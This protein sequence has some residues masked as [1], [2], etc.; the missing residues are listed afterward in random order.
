MRNRLAQCGL[1]VQE[2]TARSVLGARP[3]LSIAQLARRSLVTP[4]SMIEILT[5]LERRELLMREPDAHHARIL[6]AHLTKRGR[7]L[8]RDA[9]RAVAGIQEQILADVPP[10]ERAVLIEGMRAVMNRLS[11]GL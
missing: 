11:G 6:R 4:Q 7:D 2:Y 5:R 9:D 8:L 1:S 10:R 3:G